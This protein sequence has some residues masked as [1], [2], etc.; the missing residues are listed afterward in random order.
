MLLMFY[1]ECLSISAHR[2]MWTSTNMMLEREVR[3][4]SVVLYLLD[5]ANIHNT[6]ICVYI[7]TYSTSSTVPM[8]ER[9]IFSSSWFWFLSSSSGT[10]HS[11][12]RTGTGFQKDRVPIRLAGNLLYRRKQSNEKTSIGTTRR[13]PLRM[14]ECHGLYHCI[15]LTL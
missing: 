1:N 3:G 4:R 7:Y 12:I 8:E 9:E 5:I 14:L 2:I 10:R 6:H 13:V 11:G 15:I